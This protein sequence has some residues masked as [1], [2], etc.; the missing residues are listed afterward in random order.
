MS[1]RTLAGALHHAQVIR[2][3]GHNHCQMCDDPVSGGERKH[4]ER[5]QE[6][7]QLDVYIVLLA[8]EVER[9]TRLMKG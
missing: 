8:E 7:Y 2:D 3:G 5:Y 4:A 6:K 1:E 9:L